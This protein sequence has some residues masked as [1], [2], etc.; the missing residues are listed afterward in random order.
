MGN[1]KTAGNREKKV[2]K[3]H[4]CPICDEVMKPYKV[5]PGGKM[6]FQCTKGHVWDKTQ[7]KKRYP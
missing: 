3:E 7:T 6:Q 2:H 4:F 5:Y 1:A